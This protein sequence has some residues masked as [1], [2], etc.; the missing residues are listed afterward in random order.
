MFHDQNLFRG[1]LNYFDKVPQDTRPQPER[2]GCATDRNYLSIDSITTHYFSLQVACYTLWFSDMPETHRAGNL[3]SRATF[4]ADI[5]SSTSNRELRCH[6]L[7]IFEDSVLQSPLLAEELSL[8]LSKSQQQRSS[9]SGEKDSRQL[10]FFAVILSSAFRQ[11]QLEPFQQIITS[12]TH[13]KKKTVQMFLTSA[14][15]AI[16]QKITGAVGQKRACTDVP[17]IECKRIKHGIMQFRRANQWSH[18]EKRALFYDWLKSH[19]DALS[20]LLTSLFALLINN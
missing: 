2:H 7:P 10:E 18:A 3:S 5:A 15:K 4:F 1:V 20:A 14:L 13:V 9:V 11:A 17:P 6:R 12:L 8:S 16:F 19:R